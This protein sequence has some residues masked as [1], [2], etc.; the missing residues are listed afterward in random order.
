[1][2]RICA[3]LFTVLL[4]A[5]MALPVSGAAA[6]GSDH[7]FVQLGKK[8]A[9]QQA[10]HGKY[11]V[12]LSVPGVAESDRYSEII[13]MVDASN[14]QRNNFG[15]LKEMLLNIGSTV[16][17][18][19]GAVR[20]TLMGYGMGPRCVG[21]FYNV[22]SL[23]E[24]L[25]TLSFP[26]LRQGVSATNCEGA[27]QF[28]SDYIN[29]SSKLHKAVV[30]FTSDG[31][32]NMDETPFSLSDWQSHPEWWYMGSTVKSLAEYAAG[33]QMDL[34]LSEGIFFSATTELYFEQCQQLEI[35]EAQ[36][37]RDSA[38]YL[39]LIDAL[40][41]AI[42]AD[43][44]SQAE[45][46]NA[47]FRDA[48]A[49]SGLTYSSEAKYTTSQL[50]K[51]FLDFHGGVLTNAYLCSIHRMMN[52][53]F[54]PDWYELSTWGA[55]AASAADALAENSKVSTLYMVDFSN[56]GEIWMN[57]ASS[58]TYKVTSEKIS[59]EP[60]KNFSAA[61]E[62]IEAI[63]Q[64]TFTTAH[65]DVT[66]TDPMSKW[67]DLQ[68]ESIRIYEKDTLIYEQGTGWLSADNQPAA[69]PIA[70]TQDADGNYTIT[71]RVK[72]GPLLFTDRYTL[73]YYVTVDEQEPGF[74]YGTD[75]PANDPT[76]VSYLDE[77]GNEHV[78]PIQVPDVEVTTPETPPAHGIYL[79]KANA[80][81]GTPISGIVFDVYTLPADA[82]IDAAPTA[83]QVAEYAAETNLLTSVTT[84]EDGS[85][86]LDLTALGLAQ[87]RYL[88]VER[89]DSRVQA[90]AAPFVIDITDA[91][92]EVVRR[93]V[94]NTLKT[95][96][97]LSYKPEIPEEH[98]TPELAAAAL[99]KHRDGDSS[100][101][102][103]GTEYQFFR[104]A[105]PDEQPERVIE[106]G[107][108]QV[109]LLPLLKDG[110]TVSVKTAAG[111]LGRSPEVPYGLYYLFE[112]QAPVGYALN[113][114]PVPIFV[115]ATSAG[116][117][118][119][120]F[121]SDPMLPRTNPNTGV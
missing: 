20:L 45:Y 110:R 65:I 9:V 81:D 43:E 61:A 63:M 24:Y 2:K 115:T 17:H 29:A 13:I 11:E 102:L 39:Q 28:V 8:I 49:Y 83:Q 89:E 90:A 32:T 70:L 95:K 69:D 99:L 40:Y 73:K 97:L 53:A 1:M 27:L 93:T 76:D 25:S 50:E 79:Y 106:A 78:L 16:L 87:G 35:A 56:K 117:D 92:G 74:V 52:A 36:Y 41:A 94:H 72:D 119:A 80:A 10:E 71:W 101:R 98:E 84:D 104:I 21:S 118:Y 107:G 54:Y 3:L 77:K 86:L 6:E 19:D 33:G 60:A 26:Q 38:E 57:P 42:C 67:V 120:V 111:G 108:K 91:E 66:V 37:G 121:T 109:G 34:L 23:R 82:V 31:N 48:F 18:D 46:L 12:Q 47:A 51:V 113:P 58:K 30:V 55:R 96:T 64:T 85:A 112:V 62:R 4:L 22:E 100:V 103:A 105:E 15:K 44:Q 88:F 7:A 59:Y 68:P 75:Y 114:N 116:E 14:S 5:A